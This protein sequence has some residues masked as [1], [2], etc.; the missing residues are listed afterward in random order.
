MLFL[1]YLSREHGENNKEVNIRSTLVYFIQFHCINISSH[2]FR[3]IKNYIKEFYGIL[4][5]I[6]TLAS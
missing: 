4:F 2:L 6:E 3:G 5:I 1:C